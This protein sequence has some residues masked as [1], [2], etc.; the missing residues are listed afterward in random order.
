MSE[1]RIYER[2]GRVIY[3]MEPW[4]A[5]AV[6]AAFQRNSP[7]DRGF[8]EDALRLIRAASKAVESGHSIE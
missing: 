1:T 7:D 5:D 4:I 8:S 6:A 3:E 2:D